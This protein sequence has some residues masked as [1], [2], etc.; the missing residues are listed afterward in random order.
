M[1][2]SACPGQKKLCAFVLGDLPDRELGEMAEHLDRCSQ[3]EE[4][5]SQ[6]DDLSDT[7]LADLRRMA[8]TDNGTGTNSTEAGATGDPA[9][10][11]AVGRQWGDFLI[12]REIGRGGMG[13]V[14]EA[15]QGSLKRH[16]ALKLLP[17]P[18]DEIWAGLEAGR[19]IGYH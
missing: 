6:L 5:V 8:E 7:V 12:I 17:E 19:P 10:S 13:V 16:V 15:Y 4:W 11:T 18:G 2:N 14:C 1:I 9:F 3:C